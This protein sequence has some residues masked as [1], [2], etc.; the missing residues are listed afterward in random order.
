MI[1]LKIFLVFIFLFS[2]YTQ[3]YANN[4]LT[5]PRDTTIF[6]KC[7]KE[8]IKLADEVGA[9]YE[10]GLCECAD[11]EIKRLTNIFNTTYKKIMSSTKIDQK[12]K[13]NIKNIHINWLAYR[14]Q[15]F[16]A[17]LK[18]IPYDNAGHE[19]LR[20]T[21]QLNIL[22]SQTILLYSLSLYIEDGVGY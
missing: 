11:D 15:M 6:D 19:F 14:K 12:E 5:D 18:Y 1:R 21:H 22:K 2:C 17:I 16:N 3:S 13:E 8:A 10:V 9:D 4:A 7:E 20:T